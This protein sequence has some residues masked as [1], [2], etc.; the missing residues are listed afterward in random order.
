MSLSL[1][2]FSGDKNSFS[3][4]RPALSA[5]LGSWLFHSLMEL[6]SRILCLPPGFYSTHPWQIYTSHFWQTKSY[7]GWCGTCYIS[8]PCFFSSSD[9]WQLSQ[10]LT[11]RSI[12][13]RCAEPRIPTFRH[14]L[15]SITQ[16]LSLPQIVHR[17]AYDFCSILFYQPVGDPKKE[18]R[19]L[20]IKGLPGK[21]MPAQSRVNFRETTNNFKV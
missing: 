14:E 1:L 16:E 20:S 5:L 21:K 2:L 11:S 10:S 15:F 12:Q 18:E 6:S 13:Q 9:S 4:L 7:T 3:Y 19:Y 8:G 17:V